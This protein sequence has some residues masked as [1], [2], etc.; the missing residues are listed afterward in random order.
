[1]LNVANKPYV[2]NVVMLSVIML[3]VVAPAV[4]PVP[5]VAIR[6]FAGNSKFGRTSFNFFF[7]FE[8]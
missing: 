8:K 6:R 7:F 1:M 3:S 4:F 5:A 2:L